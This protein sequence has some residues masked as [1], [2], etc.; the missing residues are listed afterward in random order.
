MEKFIVRIDETLTKV[1]E[2]EAEDENTALEMVKDSYYKCGIVLTADDY[3]DTNFSV[4]KVEQ[5]GSL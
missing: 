2:I 1:V 5:G 4:S 3:S